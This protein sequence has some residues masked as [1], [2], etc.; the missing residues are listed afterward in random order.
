MSVIGPGH[1]SSPHP[2]KPLLSTAQ[3]E[4]KRNEG[5]SVLATGLERLKFTIHPGRSQPGEQEADRRKVCCRPAKIRHC[6][7]QRPTAE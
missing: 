2:V 6:C 3:A 7:P 4:E 5:R 1:C